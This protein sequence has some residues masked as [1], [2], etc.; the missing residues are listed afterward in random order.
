LTAQ[1]HYT[2]DD[3]RAV[4]NSLRSRRI[5]GLDADRTRAI[6]L[7]LFDTG[8]R[9]SKLCDLRTDDLDW[10]NQTLVVRT[11]KGGDQRVV[12]IGT[13]AARSLAAYLR[14]KGAPSAWLLSSLDGQRLTK[15]ALKL[16]LKR[17][18]EAAGL[19]FKGIHAFRRASGI[20]DKP[21]PRMS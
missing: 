9:A 14:L 16:L 17:A 6:V 1:P 8:V 5:K 15:N 13:S 7:M 20:A 21:E 4:L 11:T 3:V 18:F 2:P 19:P 10:E 12:S